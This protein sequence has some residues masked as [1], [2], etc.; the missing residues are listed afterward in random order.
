MTPAQR[1][2]AELLRGLGRPA[3]LIAVNTGLPLE[4]VQHWLRTGLWPGPRQ[5]TLFDASGWGIR[6]STTQPATAS[7]GNYGLSLFAR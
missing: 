7:R 1:A 3:E 4:T 6:P 2:D 5:K